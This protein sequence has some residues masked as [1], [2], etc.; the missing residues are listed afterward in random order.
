MHIEID[1]FSEIPGGWNARYF[2]DNTLYGF[3]SMNSRVIDK[4]EYALN[5]IPH[6]SCY[7][8]SSLFYYNEGMNK[9]TG[10]KDFQVMSHEEKEGWVKHPLIK[11]T[12]T[13]MMGGKYHNSSFYIFCVPDDNELM[14][15]VG[16][17]L[18]VD[19]GLEVIVRS[20]LNYLKVYPRIIP[21]L[22]RK[23]PAHLT[24]T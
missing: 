19:N 15:Q 6:T 22:L 14:F 8:L 23:E 9:L 21:V 1:L 3:G 10:K 13:G 7:P 16:D 4:G 17:L 20:R 5:V 18:G 11:A 2:I 24:I 12:R